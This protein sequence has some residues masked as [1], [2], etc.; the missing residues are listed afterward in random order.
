MSKVAISQW[1]VNLHPPERAPYSADVESVMSRAEREDVGILSIQAQD[2]NREFLLFFNEERSM[3]LYFTG[4]RSA[5]ESMEAWNG[6][7][8]VATLPNRPAPEVKRV[9]YCCPNG[10]FYCASADYA[11]PRKEAF[12][13]VREC[14][15]AEELITSLPKKRR[16]FVQ[17]LFAGM[18]EFFLPD[19]KWRAVEWRRVSSAAAL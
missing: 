15:R 12:V 4:E 10:D 19:E 3:L 13:I 2:R 6:P 16:L 7:C 14:L 11:I 18:E 1:F 8:F 5:L 17:P 9:N